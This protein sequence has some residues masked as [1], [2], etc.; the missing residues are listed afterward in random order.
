[1]PS[2]INLT[3]TASLFE[4]G[5]TNEPI[6]GRT[7]GTSS[8]CRAVALLVHGLGA[9]SGW[10]EAM[11]R[12]LKVR[13]IYAMAYDQRGFG[14]RQG[15]A[16]FGYQ[17]WLDDL[18]TVYSYLKTQATG[19]PIYLI[20]NSMGALITL[21][22]A[23][24]LKPSGLVLSSPGF[25]GYPATFTI[26]FRIKAILMALL[27]PRS[28]VCLPY[29]DDF[30]SR[31]ASVKEWIGSDPQ[32]RRLIPT[33]MLLELLKLTWKVSTQARIIECPV[34]MMT[35]GVEKIVNNK[36]NADYFERLIC[37]EKK[38]LHL[39]EAWHDLMFD[40][41]IDN[42]ADEVVSFMSDCLSDKLLAGLEHN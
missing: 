39:S 2:E 29:P 17:Q 36:V 9:H 28:Q 30:I 41:A 27:A 34:F 12:R 20:G 32:R 3:P 15:Q 31:D 10:F 4:I 14:G 18:T 22:A 33:I 37:P 40:P 35:A 38:K 5:P 19:R 8:E 24:S 13:R 7:W 1:M 6:T 42:V 26:A 25:A 21:M 23:N 11:G 16:F